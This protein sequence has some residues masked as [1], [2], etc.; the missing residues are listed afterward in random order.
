MFYLVFVS[1]SIGADITV[2][3][4][5]FSGDAM[6]TWEGVSNETL[7]A[8]LGILGGKGTLTGDCPSLWENGPSGSLGTFGLGPFTAKAHDGT[9]G[10]GN[11]ASYGSFSIEFAAPVSDF[12][13]YWG[14]PVSRDLST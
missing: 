12:G 9:H 6:E 2:I 13:G 8:P 14:N 10:F 3:P 4:N 7:L 11:S 1:G 5:E